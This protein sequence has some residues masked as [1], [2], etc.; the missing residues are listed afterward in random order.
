[1]G[2]APGSAH[3]PRR[4]TNASPR[5][6]RKRRA[7]QQMDWSE[8]QGLTFEEI[9][10]LEHSALQLEK[11]ASFRCARPGGA[12]E[13]WEWWTSDHVVA[14]GAGHARARRATS[15]RPTLG[16]AIDARRA[17]DARSTPPRRSTTSSRTR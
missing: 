12:R 15:R 8:L 5:R 4:G 1:M 14:R 9:D 7:A 10:A 3:A 6:R 17:L 16:R 2:D 11:Q 13:W